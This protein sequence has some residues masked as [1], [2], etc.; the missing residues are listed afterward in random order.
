MAER[1]SNHSA[2]LVPVLAG[3]AGAGLALLFAPR[4]GKETRAK[5]QETATDMKRQAEDGVY[6]ARDRV[7][8]G[9]NR[10][11]DMKERFTG[12]IKTSTTND[13]QTNDLAGTGTSPILTS[14]EQEV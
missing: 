3:L 1:A 6:A 9:V 4:S 2:V 7:E 10:A 12:A 13:K 8:S 11:R 5:L 14:W